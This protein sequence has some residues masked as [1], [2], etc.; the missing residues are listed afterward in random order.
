MATDEE[1]RALGALVRAALA[2]GALATLTLRRG[3]DDG[4][5]PFTAT[6]HVYAEHSHPGHPEAGMVGDGT[7]RR[8]TGATLGDALRK[9]TAP[10]GGRSP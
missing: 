4:T 3:H 5:G 2:R 1:D 9:A 7:H 6:L 8:G 10:V